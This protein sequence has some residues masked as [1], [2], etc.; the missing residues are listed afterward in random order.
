MTTAVTSMG[1]ASWRSAIG[2]VAVAVAR[3]DA[4]PSAKTSVV[5]GVSV[6]ETR[7]PARSSAS[8]VW[9]VVYEVVDPESRRTGMGMVCEAESGWGLSAVLYLSTWTTRVG[10]DADS[11][12]TR[13]FELR[14]AVRLSPWTRASV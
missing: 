6:R 8:V 4:T 12:W 2:I 9:R 13:G 14:A 3:V 1:S 11:P 10:S 7:A 5:G